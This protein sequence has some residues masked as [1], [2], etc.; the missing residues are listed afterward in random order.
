VDSEAVGDG[1]DEADG[2]ADDEADGDGPGELDG[3][4]DPWGGDD[5][6]AECGGGWTWDGWRVAGRLLGG[7]GVGV[8]DSELCADAG[9]VAE[10]LEEVPAV[11]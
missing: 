2:D 10:L 5:G 6:V 8:G 4:G 11:C 9:V 3:E 1:D 7:V